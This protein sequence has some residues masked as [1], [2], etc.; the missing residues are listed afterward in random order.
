MVINPILII[1]DI[2]EVRKLLATRLK[3][4]GF[5]VLACTPEEAMT[6]CWPNFHLVLLDFMMPAPYGGKEIVRWA[7]QSFG[8]SMPT[9]II[10][11]ALPGERLEEIAQELKSEFSFDLPII[12]L[13]KTA[14]SAKLDETINHAV[15]TRDGHSGSGA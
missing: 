2:S 11:S 14:P 10:F 3:L 13:S 1:D 4:S 8:P 9:T 15:T 7:W 12:F 6:L 5:H